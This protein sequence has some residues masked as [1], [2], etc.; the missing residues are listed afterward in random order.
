[1]RSLFFILAP[2]R[3]E[4]PIEIHRREGEQS[5]QGFLLDQR[6]KVR[7]P[8]IRAEFGLGQNQIHLA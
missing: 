3:D 5:Q 1:M 6:E 2:K 4:G 8:N 7:H